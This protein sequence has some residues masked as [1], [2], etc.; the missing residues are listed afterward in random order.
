[1]KKK[2]FRYAR[3]MVGITILII[4]FKQIELAKLKEYLLKSNYWLIALGLMH[5]PLLI[6]VG[7]IR[8]QYILTQFFKPKLATRL[9]I[10][11]YWCGV[12]IGFFTPASLGL[13]AYR[14]IYGGNVYGGYTK[15]AIA[16]IIEKILALI[17]CASLFVGLYPIVP[18]SINHQLMAALYVAFFIMICF[19]IALLS[20]KAVLKSHTV[21]RIISKLD[22]QGE[23]ILKKISQKYAFNSEKVSLAQILNEVIRALSFLKIS[24]IIAFTLAIQFVTSLKSQIFFT[25]LGYDLPFLVNLFVAPTLYFIFMLPISFGSLGIREGVYIVLYGLFGIPAEIALIVSFFNLIGMAINNLIG[26]VFMMFAKKNENHEISGHGK[27][28]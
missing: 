28:L 10:V 22:S 20:S 8:W 2:V 1:M 25:A 19:F 9:A 11:H 21:M 3:W 5:S 14:V 16:V 17:T 24:N 15:N 27:H 26:A 18:I 6:L 12:A 7:A 4:V 23:R 13:D